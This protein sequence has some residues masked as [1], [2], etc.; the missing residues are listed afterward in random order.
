MVVFAASVLLACSWATAQ[1]LVETPANGRESDGPL[2]VLV[3]Y[4]NQRTLPANQQVQEGIWTSVREAIAD[5]RIEL[6]EEYLETHRLPVGDEDPPMVSYLERRYREIRPEV[7]VAVGPQSMQFY[8]DWL[9]EVFPRAISVFAVLREDQLREL[10]GPRPEVGVLYPTTT[11]PLL[12]AARS[13][14]PGIR[15]VILVGGSADFDRKLLAEIK[16]Q[17]EASFSWEVSE[18][19]GMPPQ[20]MDEALAGATQDQVVLFTSFFKDESGKAYIPRDVI[21]QVSARSAVPIFAL[22]ETMIGHGAAGIAVASFSEQGREVGE[23]LMRLAG[24]ESPEEIGISMVSSP[25]LIF[26]DRE[27]RRYRLNPAKLP[28]D[29]EILFRKRSIIE[30]HPV[31]FAV[32]TATIAV[33]SLLIAA[34]LVMRHRKM[35]AERKAREME[36]YFSTVFQ[37]SPNPMAVIG[38][39]DGTFQDINPAWE[40]LYGVSRESSIGRTPVEVGILLGVS[41]DSLYEDFVKGNQNLAGYE[42]QIQTGS[43]EVRN[44][45]FFSNRVQMDGEHLQIIT[46]VDT[47]DRVEAERLRRNLA[48]DNRVAQLGQI[49]AW[50]AHE[51]NQPLGS[52]LN[53]A[54]TGLMVLESGKEARADLQEI[55]AEIKKEDRRAS[56]IVEKIRSMLGRHRT[57]GERI[58]TRDILEEVMRTAT[59]EAIRRSVRL[60]IESEEIPDVFVYADRILLQQ[61]FLNLV[62]NAMDAVAEVPMSNRFV[63]LRCEV[64]TE[65]RL[66]DF[67]VCDE[68]KGVDPAEMETIFEFFHTTKEEGLGLGLA[69]SRAILKDHLGD[70]IVE[71]L[72]TGG[73]CFHVRLPLQENPK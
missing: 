26:D 38:V 69:I 2:V 65:N 68:G 34:L 33:Q 5:R 62:F 7:V 1:P 73:A 8:N 32:G 15:E 71:N 4:S 50:I 47:E 16:N 70:L 63:T 45:A 52:I 64:L 20:L 9:S 22:F 40:N 72:E 44:V 60:R 36:H 48:R 13:L 29:A 49:S 57:S 51:I 39:V 10:S 6:F 46:T 19:S 24:G 54:E 30:A 59:P 12:E 17:I 37:K 11:Q 25:E 21:E 31:A 53:N 43:G 27:L 18:L 23:I 61:V 14:I 3:L 41:D 28:A 35:K 42:R 66:V 67:T 55:L 56:G 58:A